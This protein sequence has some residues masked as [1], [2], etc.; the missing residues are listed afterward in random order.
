[1]DVSGSNPAAMPPANEFFDAYVKALHAGATQ[2]AAVLLEAIEKISREHPSSRAA[3]DTTAHALLI[4][5]C[6]FGALP[7]NRRAG[8]AFNRLVQ[9]VMTPAASATQRECLRTALQRSEGEL[10]RKGDSVAPIRQLAE[11][12]ES[13]PTPMTAE[14]SSNTP[15]A[16][17]VYEVYWSI[18]AMVG[19]DSKRQAQELWAASRALF[20]RGF[21]AYWLYLCELIQNEYS[22]SSSIEART[23]AADALFVIGATMGTNGDHETEMATYDVLLSRFATQIAPVAFT[24]F[25]KGLRL[26]ER[27]EPIRALE[28]Y[29][30]LIDE[31]KY[32]GDPAI[33]HQVAMA[34]VNRAGIWVQMQQLPRAITDLDMVLELFSK[35]VSPN[36]RKQCGLALHNKAIVLEGAG[37]YAQAISAIDELIRFHS[38]SGDRELENAVAVA[39]ESR[40]LL[41]QKLGADPKRT[42]V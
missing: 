19:G 1:M 35:D 8:S 34:L 25:N 28:A 10:L 27:K 18:V 16:L 31:F 5:Y 22:T 38:Q 24:L 6:F 41:A 13:L 32:V 12:L 30:R 15:R 23:I 21:E 26:C 37:M 42:I 33:R 4:E 39:V 11:A 7:G 20:E 17:V 40:S 14:T 29:S 2:V 36:V 3:N 9:L